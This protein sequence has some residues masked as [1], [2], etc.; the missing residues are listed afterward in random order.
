MNVKNVNFSNEL[1]RYMDF[2]LKP[3]F[4]AAGPIMGKKI[5][6]FGLALSQVDPHEF[7]ALLNKNG[8]VNLNI[9]GEDTLVSKELI[10]VRIDAKDGFAVAVENN[11][12]TIC[13]DIV[14]HVNQ[15]RYSVLLCQ[16]LSGVVLN[17]CAERS[18][19]RRVGKECRSRW[20]PYH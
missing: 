1:S 17:S 15:Q 12:F 10:D 3:D 7:T 9:D 6:A 4:K 11:F 18:E 20:S 14:F 19:E 2:S 13:L 8:E 5:K 16:F